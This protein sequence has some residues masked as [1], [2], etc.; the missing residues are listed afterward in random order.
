MLD[1]AHRAL[2]V[3]D[4]SNLKPFK[5]PDTMQQRLSDSCGVTLYISDMKVVVVE[6]IPNGVGACITSIECGAS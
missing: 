6:A 1:T 3:P 4:F 2:E 5:P